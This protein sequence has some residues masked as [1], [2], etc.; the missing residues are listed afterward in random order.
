MVAGNGD[1]DTQLP[2]LA[3]CHSPNRNTLRS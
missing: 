2:L 3:N 1:H